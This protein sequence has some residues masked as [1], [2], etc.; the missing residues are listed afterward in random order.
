MKQM[1]L[2]KAIPVALAVLTL[3]MFGS[4]VTM[5]VR[6][7]KVT[8]LRV[9]A[10]SHT[11]ESYMLCSALK[12]VVA[13]YYP[14]IAIEL[15]ETK[16]TSEN[17]QMLE[18]DAADIAAAQADVAPGP[19]A[20]SVAVMYDDVFQLLAHESSNV[21]TFAQAR[22]KAVALARGGGQ[23]HSFLHVAEHFGLTEQDF[24]FVG[25]T[26]SEADKAFSQ[27][28]ADVL[29]R[30]RALGN[31]AI[32]S[33]AAENNVRFVPIEHAAAM[34]IKQ[35]AFLPAIV[36]VGAY[37]GEPPLPDAD[38]P[39][40]AVA[41]TLLARAGA[42]ESAI[43]KIARVLFEHR[44]EIMK[45]FPDDKTSVR[46]LLSQVRRPD[47]QT[48][49]VPPVHPGALSFYDQDEPS[50]VAQNADYVGLIFSGLFMLASWAWQLKSWVL[51]QQ[52]Q[53]AD[54]YSKVSIQLMEKAQS[55]ETHARLDEIRGQLLK[56]LA[57]AVKALDEDKLSEDSFQSFRVV[58]QIALD[59]VQ[60]RRRVLIGAPDQ[61]HPDPTPEPH[62]SAPT[63][64]GSSSLTLSQ[65]TV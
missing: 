36:P 62:S 1:L 12:T 43:D 59:V 31:P 37:I 8:T 3:V 56:Q 58:L 57:N 40:V 5:L 44:Q 49:L 21:R 41:R 42:D 6:A 11:G 17:L 61:C 54:E 29:F 27:G 46:V 63:E 53:E 47:V 48:E 14:N 18:N 38:L 20:R 30:V 23:F 15:L 65:R 34:K 16:G 60:D 52:K 26:D 45:E 39:T 24:Q 22:G 25:N 7:T 50:Y 28:R 64:P 4:V 10:G 9:A 32:Q 55:A 19:S 2:Q 13:R 35:P 51:R 33:L